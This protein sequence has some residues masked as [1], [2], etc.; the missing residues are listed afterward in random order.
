MHIVIFVVYDFSIRLVTEREKQLLASKQYTELVHEQKRVDREID[1]KVTIK[2]TYNIFMPLLILG[3]RRSAGLA[4]QA[5]S[6]IFA[7]RRVVSI[8]NTL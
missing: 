5:V 1:Q 6:G 3:Y 8:L 7:L 2:C 4:L